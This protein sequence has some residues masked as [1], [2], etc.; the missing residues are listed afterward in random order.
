LPFIAPVP[1]TTAIQ[2]AEMPLAQAVRAIRAG[3]P[4]GAVETMAKMFFMSGDELAVKLGISPRTVRD[5]RKKAARLS[6]EITEKLVRAAR[7]QRL[8]RRIF[9]TDEAVAQ[10]LGAPAPA[11][12][13]IAP[14]D[15]L[16]TDTGA[17]EVEDLLQ[18]IAYGHAM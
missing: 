3:L 13:G 12:E 5:K 18:G 10:W 2:V 8:A 16:D 15:L 14:I 11:L 4:A 6:R 17:R 9:S 7:V 1:P